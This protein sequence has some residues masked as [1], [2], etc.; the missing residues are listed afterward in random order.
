MPRPLPGRSP[1]ARRLRRA[2]SALHSNAGVVAFVVFVGQGRLPDGARSRVSGRGT[3]SALLFAAGAQAPRRLECPEQGGS[4][5]GAARGVGR[6]RARGRHRRATAAAERGAARLRR[7]DATAAGSAV[8]A[9]PR[10]GVARRTVA[11][12][13]G[14]SGVASKARRRR[15]LRRRHPRRLLPV[16]SVRQKDRDDVCEEVGAAAVRVA[17]RA[18]SVPGRARRQSERGAPLRPEAAGVPLRQPGRRG[19]GD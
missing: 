9:A 8:G 10:V 12:R 14:V 17:L 7:R 18:Q 19:C 15:P 13:S 5:R 16:A 1:G 11:R 4:E 3:K 6:P 2:R